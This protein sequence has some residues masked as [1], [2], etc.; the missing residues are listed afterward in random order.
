MEESAWST[1]FGRLL[2]IACVVAAV[3]GFVISAD[4]F[5]SRPSDA[6]SANVTENYEAAADNLEAA[7]ESASID[8]L[9]PTAEQLEAQARAL[10]QEASSLEAESAP[11]EE[12]AQEMPMD[13]NMALDADATSGVE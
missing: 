7:A 9:G 4:F 5:A 10:E 1:P 3:V 8:D 11:I 13:A 12:T 2:A 6:S